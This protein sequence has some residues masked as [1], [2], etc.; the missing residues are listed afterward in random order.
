MLATKAFDNA[1]PAGAEL[2]AFLFGL[3]CCL[4]FATSAT[5]AGTTGACCLTLAGECQILTPAECAE[6]GISYSGDD[7]VCSP[8]PCDPVTGACCADD[9][10]CLELN[11]SNCAT[12]G[13]FY[14]GDRTNCGP[15]PC[16]NPVIG[17]CCAGNGVCFVVVGAICL[18]SDDHTYE[19]DNTTCTPNPCPRINQPPRIRTLPKPVLVENEAVE[20]TVSIRDDSAVASAVC[21]FREGGSTTS[22]IPMTQDGDRFSAA[23]L[24]SDVTPRGLGYW[25]VA[26]DE[27]GAFASSDECFLQVDVGNV[28]HGDP[29]PSGSPESAYRI[30]SLPLAPLDSR[31]SSVFEDDLGIYDPETWRLFSFEPDQNLKEFEPD[32]PIK[33][34]EGYFLLV[35]AAE[36]VL[37]TGP[38]RS[39]PLDAEFSIPLHA[40][41]NLV[42][43]PFAFPIP[44]SNIRLAGGGTLDIRRY[45]GSWSTHPDGLVP[46][47]G[48]AV[49][50][51]ED[52]S[53]LV[54]PAVSEGG[55]GVRSSATAAQERARPGLGPSLDWS[56]HVRARSGNALDDDNVAGVHREGS[57]ELDPF[58]RPEPPAIGDYVQV[59]FP[60]PDWNSLVQEL[61]TDVRAPNVPGYVWDLVVASNIDQPVSLELSDTGNLPSGATPWL[62]D[63]TAGLVTN[64][65]EDATY[66][67]HSLVSSRELQLVV[68]DASF[69]EAVLA[70]GETSSFEGGLRGF[71]TPFRDSTTLTFRIAHPGN[72]SIAIFD[73][74]GGLVRQLLA[75]EATGAG[76]Q[77]LVW[78]G[79]DDSGRSVPSGAYYA[80]TYGDGI[81]ETTRLSIVR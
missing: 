53:L 38:G 12:I 41:W 18:R 24:G 5:A 15:Y 2:R 27:D 80:R 66:E 20:L 69:L 26:T 72:I 29:Q 47:A 30:V 32:L 44:R 49:F 21:S 48:Y 35:R 40:G 1:T 17:A 78:D 14:S 31:A 61:S 65:R 57:A 13:G 36:R 6:T 9:G 76:R 8:N 64:V 43:S 23:I 46:F 3:A 28:I 50:V 33:L 16:A 19:G 56:L 11:E 22:T 81:E 42:G 77:S 52:D 59:S 71:P 10:S 62:V 60:H 55:D 67:I 58:D 51:T 63:R 25:I 45:E 37:D 39:T 73:V 7:T 4:G 79:K 74:S 70:S 75:N 68:G 34:G 54:S